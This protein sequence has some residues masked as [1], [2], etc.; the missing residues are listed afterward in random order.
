ML[1]PLWLWWLCL[2]LWLVVLLFLQKSVDSEVVVVVV[3]EVGEKAC[4]PT[5]RDA[6]PFR[7][8]SLPSRFRKRWE[9]SGVVR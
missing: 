8:F 7:P 3:E 6:P 2:W 4:E 5:P 9:G 1:L